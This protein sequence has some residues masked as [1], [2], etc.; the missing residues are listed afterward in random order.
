MEQYIIK[1]GK[2]LV[3]EVS[4]SGYKN[5][6]L[7]IIAAAIMTD[8]TVKIENVPDVKD[9]DVLLQAI[10]NIGARVDRVNRNTVKI[11]GGRIN[12]A[13]VDFDYVRKIRASYYLV[14]SLLGKYKNSKVALP[15]GCNIGSRP[16]DQ[17]IKGFEALGA[18][19]KIE[20][21]LI[22]ASAE[23][24]AGAHIYF[25]GSSVGATINTMLAACLADGLTILEN[26]AK[27]PHVVDVANFLNSM[28]AN[29]KGAGTDVIRI[30]GVQKLHGSEY[31]II[32]DQIEAGTFM[33]AAAASK[34]DILIKNVIPKHLEAF[35]AK[36]LEIGAQVQEFD[37]AVRVRASGK[38]GNS[39]VKTLVYPGFLTDMQPQMTTLLAVSKGT[40]IVTE[41]IFENRF[42]YVDELSRMGASI[43][44]E[45]NTAIIDGVEKLT[46]A[47]VCAPDLRGGAALVIAGLMA[48]GFTIVENVEYI[49]R[50]YEKFEFK[51]QQLGA[52]I[53]KV[54]SEDSKTIRKFKLKV[55]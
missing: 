54:D 49:E 29:I 44:V 47:V 5:A 34:G 25:D 37:D 42:K 52:A 33:F 41:S 23:N 31:S 50:G 40:S 32:P 38:L 26:S 2:P 22:C 20:H 27:E 13:S 15:G 6:A 30:K 35:T 11:N 4:I 24:L 8:E 12:S 14:G 3:G 28:G 17:H 19:V 43:K 16:I 10:E 45:S 53:V 1:G 51:M 7:G 21:G 9:I 39:H 55:S 36:L 46:G 18:T 48:E